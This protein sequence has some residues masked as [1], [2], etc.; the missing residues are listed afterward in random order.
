[1]RTLGEIADCLKGTLVGGEAGLTIQGV[2]PIRE[3]QPGRIT[4]VGHRRYLSDLEKT[5]ASAVV[6]ANDLAPPDIRIPSI[7]VANAYYAFAQLMALF[8]RLPMPPAGVHPQASVGK[9]RLGK[10]ISI[11]PFVTVSDNAVIGD[12]VVLYPGVYVGEG[13][14]IGEESLIYPQVTLREGVTI[15]KR[16]II[17]SGSVIGSDGYGFVFHEGKHHKIL[18][19][20]GVVIE[21]DVEIGANVTIDRGTLGN[22][23]IKRGTKMD[24]LVQIGHN[25]V[26]GEHTLLVAQSG[27]SG[28]TELGNYVVLAGQAGVAGHLRIS[29]NVRVSAKGGVTKDIPSGQTVSGFPAVPHRDWLKAQAVFQQLPEL[30]EKIAALERRLAELQGRIGNQKEKEEPHA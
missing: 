5:K 11:G 22:T 3:A 13:V 2:S 25:V 19:A 1:M 29:D 18:Q 30:K 21:D 20:G 24:N 27:I 6:I 17:H 26:V 15:G 28:S 10:E 14:Q 16:V 23:H 7:R 12:R 4:F 9:S 8:Y